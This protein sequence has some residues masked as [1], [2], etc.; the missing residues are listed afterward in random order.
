[1]DMDNFVFL[2]SSFVLVKFISFVTVY[3]FITSL[4]IY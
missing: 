3:V 2:F 4:D 1:M